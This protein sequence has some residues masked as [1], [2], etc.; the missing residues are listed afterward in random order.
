AISEALSSVQGFL[1]VIKSTVGGFGIIAVIAAFVPSV[2]TVLMMQLSL[3]I[4]GGV[5]DALGTDKITSLVHSAQSVLS[6]ILG[7][8][9]TFAVLLIVSLGIMLTVSGGG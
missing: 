8:T 1:G 7:I 4:A 9:I 5:S 3:A 2:V 6:L